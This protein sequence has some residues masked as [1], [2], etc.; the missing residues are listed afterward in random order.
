MTTETK[1]SY[2]KKIKELEDELRKTTND[3]YAYQLSVMEIFDGI[4]DVVSKG[5]SINTGWVLAKL[6]RCLK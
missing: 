3:R 6:K 2:Q 4:V 5:Q 1:Y